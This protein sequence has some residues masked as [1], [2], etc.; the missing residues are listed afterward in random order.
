MPTP[1]RDL[2]RV[3]AAL[4]GLPAALRVLRQP[5]YAALSALMLV[6]ALGCIGAGTWQI[7]RFEDKVH[8]N[9]ALTANAHADAAPIERVLP[10]VGQPAPSA[11]AVRYRTVTATGRYDPRHQ[12]LVR[13][14]TVG[15]KVGYYVLTPLTT[16]RATLLVVRGFVGERADGS[17]PDSVAAPPA[18][19]VHVRARAQT[20]ESQADLGAGLPAGQVR[21]INPDAQAARLG[22]PTFDG[23][24]QLLAGQPGTNGLTALP[25]PDL[26]NPA[27]GAIEPQH[28][29]YIVQWYIFAIL[30]LAAPFAMA[31]ADRRER[32][33]DAAATEDAEG[34]PAPAAV[35]PPVSPPPELSADERRT[36]KLADRYGRTVSHPSDRGVS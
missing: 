17:P 3:R 10:L 25:P 29:A 31:R 15:N 5:R 26:S 22:R 24:A 7:V 16:G 19:V 2:V 8:A 28:F 30:A 32:D 23:Y 36:A 11:D 27:G 6:V 13:L 34:T 4:A 9:D 21:S 1:Y 12:G 14:R 35:E 33:R 18:G 20:G